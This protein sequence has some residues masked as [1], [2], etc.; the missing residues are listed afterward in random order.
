M[1]IRRWVELTPVSATVVP[2]RCA[3]A[4]LTKQQLARQPDRGAAGARDRLEG[5]RLDP[6]VGFPR[7][8]S[9]RP[10]HHPGYAVPVDRSR[11]G[12][13]Q[14]GADLGDA[15]RRAPLDG[16]AVLT[17]A[18]VSDAEL[19]VV[20]LTPPQVMECTQDQAHRWARAASSGHIR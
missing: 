1:R 12:G 15:V 18:S 3:D 19:V 14:G 7:R 20:D 2:M 4:V 5:Q 11:V 13:P 8:P 9:E 10:V 6:R 17:R 16:G